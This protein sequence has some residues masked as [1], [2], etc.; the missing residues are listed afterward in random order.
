MCIMHERDLWVATL[1][2][3]VPTSHMPSSRLLHV[4]D[5][6]IFDSHN[7]DFLDEQ[8]APGRLTWDGGDVLGY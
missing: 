5:E 8:V 3:A 7:F 2:E 4:A 1:D 6:P